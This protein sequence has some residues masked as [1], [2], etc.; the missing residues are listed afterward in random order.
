[1]S[2]SLAEVQSLVL[3]GVVEGDDDAL[4]LVRH[5][6]K[7]TTRTMFG[8]YRNAYVLRLIEFIGH[9][10]ERL[11]LLM[12]DGF[13]AM[14]RGY[15]KAHPSDTPNARWYAR[16]LPAFLASQKPWSEQPALADLA[17][18]EKALNDAFDAPDD[19]LF[20]LADL[21]TFDPLA[22]AEAKVSFHSSAIRLTAITNVTDLWSSPDAATHRL[23][24]AIELLV[25]RQGGSSRFRVLAAEEAMAIDSARKGVPFGVLC[26]MIAL[27]DDPENAALRA[28]GYLRNWIE[29]EI[30]SA[31]G[32]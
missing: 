8:V 26:E 3:K 10:Y 1:M 27:M 11:K 17:T 19:P 30:V 2:P 14:A 22:I 29:T 25:W 5:P 13:D 20:T 28:A 12:R 15:I 6:P 24:S 4:A 16:H 31:L 21:A 23:G 9:D 32:A 7:D 18:L